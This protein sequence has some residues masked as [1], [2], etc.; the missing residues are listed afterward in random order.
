MTSSGKGSRLKRGSKASKRSAPTEPAGSESPKADFEELFACF[1]GRKVRYLIVGGYAVAFHA[2]P[3]YTKDIDLLIERSPRNAA[4]VLAALQDFFGASVAQLD[5][6]DFLDPDGILVLG[7][8]PNRVDIL[9]AIPGIEFAKS[10][11]QRVESRYGRETVFFISRADLLRNKELVGR[12][13]DRRDAEWLRR[14]S[15]RARK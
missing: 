12:P 6:A 3:R 13:V 7:V 14:A 5:R 15:V 11:K 2:K 1:N 9:N 4:R 10:W 8:A